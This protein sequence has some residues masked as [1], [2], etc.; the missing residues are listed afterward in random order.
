M[1]NAQL[2]FHGHRDA[3]K[4]FVSVPMQSQ[5]EIQ[6]GQKPNMLVMSGGEGYID[7]RLGKWKFTPFLLIYIKT[8]FYTYFFASVRI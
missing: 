3:V 6:I 5:S 1:A 2:S 8:S 7:F 4:F